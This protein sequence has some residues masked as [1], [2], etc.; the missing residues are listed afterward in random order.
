MPFLSNLRAMQS[1]PQ[2]VNK[3]NSTKCSKPRGG[4]G[5]NGILKKKKLHNLQLIVIARN[6]FLLT[7]VFHWLSRHIFSCSLFVCPTFMTSPP[8][9]T[10]QCFSPTNHMF[11]AN[12]P[13]NIL[14]SDVDHIVG[15][16][17]VPNYTYFFPYPSTSPDTFFS[18]FLVPFHHFLLL[19]MSPL[20]PP[21][22]HV[23]SLIH[24]CYS[25][26]T[27][28][29]THVTHYCTQVTHSYTPR[30]SL[31]QTTYILLQPCYTPLLPVTGCYIPD[32]PC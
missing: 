19:L 30:Y 18:F 7:P 9:S 13:L 20:S 22:H 28:S 16:N 2:S 4:R 14:S 1:A 12:L 24:S 11:S 31:L 27:L 26:V 3:K 23:T 25:L 6:P 17:R 32:M 15:S 29:Y 8:I 10:K 5:V 21:L